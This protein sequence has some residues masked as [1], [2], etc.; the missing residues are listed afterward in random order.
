MNSEHTL[1]QSHFE[2]QIPLAKYFCKRLYPYLRRYLEQEEVYQY[3]LWGIW[4]ALKSYNP[5]YVWSSY[6]F[7]CVRSKLHN[8]VSGAGMQR[9]KIN[10]DTISL[11][12]TYEDGDTKLNP[13]VEEISQELI[14]K[15]LIR[16]HVLKLKRSF[17]RTLY[18]HYV[19]NMTFREIASIEGCSKSR[20]QQRHAAAMRILEPQL[21]TAGF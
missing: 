5:K 15:M 9:R 13:F 14:D 10:F 18:M 6:A 11:D 17:R 1:T 16:K 7:L 20:I 8:I 4:E 2:E 21:K 19:L 3:C 12:V